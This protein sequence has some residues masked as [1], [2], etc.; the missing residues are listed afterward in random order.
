MAVSQTRELGQTPLV[1]VWVTN[2]STSPD[3]DIEFSTDP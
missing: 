3:L 2:M 1:L